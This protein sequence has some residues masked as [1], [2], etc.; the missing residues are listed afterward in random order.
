MFHYAGG[1][2]RM[3]APVGRNGTRYDLEVVRKLGFPRVELAKELRP[4]PPPQTGNDAE[5]NQ[6]E[7]VLTKDS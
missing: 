2:K 5:P 7:E 6:E 4:P 3:L 1:Y